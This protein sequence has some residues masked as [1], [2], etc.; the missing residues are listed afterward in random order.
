MW[1]HLCGFVTSSQGQAR[2]NVL[3]QCT[4]YLGLK[5]Q[6]TETGRHCEEDDIMTLDPVGSR[7]ILRSWATQRYGILWKTPY[8]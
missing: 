3:E 5:I 2:P 7:T 6:S 8:Q 4:A 1:F